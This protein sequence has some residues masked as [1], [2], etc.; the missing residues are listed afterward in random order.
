[1]RKS[2]L[3]IGIVGCGKAAERWH[4]PAYL[5][6]KNSTISAV[7][8]TNYALASSVAR[9]YGINRFYSS[10]P[11]MLNKEHLDILDICV[12][13][14]QHAALAIEGIKAGCH[15]LVE[16]PIAVNSAEVDDMIEASERYGRKICVTHNRLFHPVVTRALALVNNGT[17]GTFKGI[18]IRDCLRSDHESLIDER[19]W[20]HRLPAGV[21][22]EFLPHSVY[23]AYKFIG[24][25]EQIEVC[26]RKTRPASWLVADEVRILIGGKQGIAVIVA[27]CNFPKN[28][29]TLDMSGSLKRLHVDVYRS[30][31]ISKGTGKEGRIWGAI[32]NLDEA[33]QHVTC[34][35]AAAANT[36]AGRYE[37]GHRVLIKQFIQS[38]L[39][40][41]ESPVP[42]EE[43]RL[44]LIEI[45]KIERKIKDQLKLS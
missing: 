16:K 8:D 36:L 45:G 42:P 5:S 11:D 31:L 18:E 34:T 10:V 37:V 21:F 12:P 27:S 40:N 15:V 7:C 33:C 14:S 6:D 24:S 17:I 13:Q 9:K 25:F 41:T 43:G 22:S 32:D 38:I 1:M 44:Q 35:V 20:T 28:T 23:I 19:H 4:I 3:K 26:A 30:L 2:T 39:N 29:N